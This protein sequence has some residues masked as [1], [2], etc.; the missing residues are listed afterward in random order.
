[1][2]A[3]ITTRSWKR[4]LLAAFIAAIAAGGYYAWQGLATKPLEGIAYGNGRIE[5][6]EI[7]ISTRVADRIQEIVVD[8]GDLVTAGQVIALMDTEPLQAQRREALARLRQAQ[9]ALDTAES[10]LVQRRADSGAASAAVAQ[11]TAEL[12]AATKRFARSERLAQSGGTAQQVL[13]DDR[14]Q[15]NV[16]TAAVTV[17]HAQSQAAKA[18]ISAAMSQVADAKAAIDAAQATVERFDADI[19]DSSLKAPRDGRVQYRVAQPGE[20]LEAGGRVLNM[21]DTSNVFMTFFLPTSQTWSVSYGAEVRIA[22]DGAP[23]GFIPAT[24][25]FVSDVSQFTPRTVET[26]QERDKLM[27]RVKARIPAEITRKHIGEIK[28]GLPGVAYV[29]LDDGVDW[30]PQVSGTPLR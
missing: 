5:A 7:D 19:N 18:A 11:R 8:E 26:S 2:V 28:S 21:L 30:P 13:D 22:L 15:A 27:F 9:A 4:W 25:S 12:D 14:A 29:K 16:S 24:I 10:E 6:V 17:A 3:L 20:V 23:G 1:M